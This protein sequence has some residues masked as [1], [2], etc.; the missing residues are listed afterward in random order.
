MRSDVAGIGIALDC[1]A[2]VL[3]VDAALRP[4]AIQP[5]TK[6]CIN[7]ADNPSSLTRMR[8]YM[9]FHQCTTLRISSPCG[10]CTL[11]NVCYHL[12]TSGGSAQP[13]HISTRSMAWPM[14]SLPLKKRRRILH[15]VQQK[16]LLVLTVP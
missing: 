16:Y 12:W 3:G 2:T 6:P 4:F 14:R 15:A 7:V 5:W 11:V 9:V 10:V 8:F 1:K 13:M